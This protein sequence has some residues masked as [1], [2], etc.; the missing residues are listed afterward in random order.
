M[1]PP[2]KVVIITLVMIVIARIMSGEI[3]WIW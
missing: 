1:M 3:V 2:V